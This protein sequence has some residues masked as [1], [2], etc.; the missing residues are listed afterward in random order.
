[1]YIKRVY[2]TKSI[3]YSGLSLSMNPI[4]EKRRDVLL[5]VLPCVLRG[6]LLRVF[7]GDMGGG[8]EEVPPPRFL[9]LPPLDK[10]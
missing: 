7:N 6:A 3:L 5:R 1:M 9:R 2:Q 8:A 4:Y 10:R